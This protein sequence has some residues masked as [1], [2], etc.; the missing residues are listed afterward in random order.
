MKSIF[1]ALAD[2]ARQLEKTSDTA[3]LDSELLMAEALHIDRDKLILSP[4]SREVPERFWDMVE[5]RK[6][7]ET[8]AQMCSR[9]L[10]LLWSLAVWSLVPTSILL[11]SR[12]L[13]PFSDLCFASPAITLV[14]LAYIVGSIHGHLSEGRSAN[15]AGILM[16]LGLLVRWKTRSKKL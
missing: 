6:A 2:A 11:A 4:P 3:R 10:Q 15:A 12:L 13:V 14:V 8:D 7:G 1:R 16:M 9:E 5:R